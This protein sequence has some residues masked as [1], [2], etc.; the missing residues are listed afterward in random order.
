MQNVD[1]VDGRSMDFP[2]KERPTLPG[3]GGQRNWYGL[4]ISQLHSLAFV[5]RLG[6]Y[7]PTANSHSSP[8]PLAP[9]ASH[10]EW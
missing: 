1:I 2:V 4:S 5:I 9:A 6:C 10:N 3:G 7:L 8:P